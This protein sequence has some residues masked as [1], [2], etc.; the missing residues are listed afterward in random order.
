MGTWRIIYD[1]LTVYV[2]YLAANGEWTYVGHNG[3]RASYTLPEGSVIAIGAHN[4]GG[5]GSSQRTIAIA[6]AKIT[7]GKAV[8]EAPATFALARTLSIEDALAALVDYT[9]LNNAKV[10]LAAMGDVAEDDAK[11]VAL[12][13]AITAMEAATTQEDLDKAAADYAAKVETIVD[14]SK[15]N[16][17]LAQAEKFDRYGYTAATWADFF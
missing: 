7:S 10:E 17:Q 2:Q 15:L 4:R 11:A 13:D 5:Q 12:K 14:L 3:E 6:S 8:E 16:Y 9:A 1:G